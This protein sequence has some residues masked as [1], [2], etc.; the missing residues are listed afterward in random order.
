MGTKTKD[1]IQSEA[2]GVLLPA[3][4]GG[5]G[6]TMGA[7]KTIL[8]LKHFNTLIKRARSIE[9]APL[10]ALVVA[11]KK[12]IFKS[13]TDDAEEFGYNSLLDQITFSTYRS[14]TKQDL[15]Y[16]VIYLDE[17]HSLLFSHKPWLK[18]YSGK[19]IGLT[20][21]PPK[22]PTSE[23]GKMV[24]EFCPILYTYITDEAVDDEILNDYRII[25]HSL[26][27][28]SAK[29]MLVDRGEK[30][31][32]TSELKTYT[33]WT[34]RYNDTD[35]PKTRQI[36]SVQRMKAMQTFP[37][38]EEYAKRLL[39][40]SKYK[41]LLFANTKVQADKL[42]SHSYHS[43]N[44]ASE[45]NLQDFKDGKISKMSCVLQLNE[46]VNIPEL[47]EG[48]IMHAYGNNRKSAQ[49]IGRLLRLNPDDVATIHI[50]CYKGTVDERWVTQALADFDQDKISWYDPEIF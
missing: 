34:D 10:K 24:S 35:S 38:K 12:S 33:Y 48:I 41:C 13:W 43:G 29:T 45:D 37:S 18:Q 22:Y 42:C 17:C 25:V 21:T 40:E 30:K 3:H 9:R 44:K 4:R 6:I 11:P 39:V 46:G 36:L 32:Y 15:D 1:D 26:S 50:L 5:A 16:D 14:L 49:R 19:I 20:G 31:W 27:L 28:D 23:K 7:G 8:G 47:K 2:L